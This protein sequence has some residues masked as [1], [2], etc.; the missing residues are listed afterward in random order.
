MVEALRYNLEIVGAIPDGVIGIFHL[1]N[2]SGRTVVFRSTRLIPEMSTGNIYCGEG[3]G[4]GPLRMA[5]SLATF[6]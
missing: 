1:N 5:D 3:G 6:M 2:P 4:R